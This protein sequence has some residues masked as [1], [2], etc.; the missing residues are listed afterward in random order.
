MSIVLRHRSHWLAL[1]S[2]C[3]ASAL[4]GPS[5]SNPAP[6]GVSM[7]CF[8]CPLPSRAIRHTRRS[9]TRRGPSPALAVSAIPA[10][11]GRFPSQKGGGAPKP[12]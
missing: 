8:Q 4:K 5:G 10:E 11:Q 3:W 6:A 12:G 1:P 7:S 2:E 9:L